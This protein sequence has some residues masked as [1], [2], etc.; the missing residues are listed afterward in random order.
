MRILPFLL[1]VPLSPLTLHAQWQWTQ[2]I[3]S[4]T[5]DGYEWGHAC[6]VGPDHTLA[7]AGLWREHARLG[8]LEF[9][10]A[11]DPSV[12]H[13]FVA[14][15]DVLGVP[16]WMHDL[17]TAD[18]YPIGHID[19]GVDAE[20][21]LFVAGDAR[22]PLLVD[23][24]PGAGLDGSPDGREY[25][26]IKFAPD[27]TY[28]W[29]R[30]VPVPLFTGE[31]NAL[32]VD[33]AG[34][35]WL[36]GHDGTQRGHIFKLSG[37][38]GAELVHHTTEGAG[39]YVNDVKTDAA[40]NAYIIGFANNDFVIGGVTC[41]H[42]ADL[43]AST[44]QWIGKFDAGGA[45]QWFHVPS[46]SGQGFP[47]YPEG[48]LAVTPDGTVFTDAL[49]RMRFGDDTIS[50]GSP[51]L[52]GIYALDT[53]GNVLFARKANAT[54]GLYFTE[55]IG[56]AD[57]QALFLGHFNGNANVD[58][59]DTSVV[60]EPAGN[61]L[62]L[63]R[64]AAD[65]TTTA[66]KTGPHITAA[67]GLDLDANGAPAVCGEFSLQPAF[68]G[69]ALDGDWD[70][71]ALRSAPLPTLVQDNAA[72][73]VFRAFPNPA[74]TT[75]HLVGGPGGPV[76]LEVLDPTGRLLQRI[77]RFDPARGPL[78]LSALPPGPLLLRL[79]G[80]WGSTTLRIVHLP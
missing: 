16:V 45:P 44:S 60:V 62:M 14:K 32:D 1:L 40:G 79:A 47:V 66:V 6:A 55:A 72:A 4:T 38:D 36:V 48:N 67:R 19:M 43:G 80:A 77:T 13:G 76:T 63:V 69:L 78:D 23:G 30:H 74:H 21:D 12:V 51:G 57:G 17:S 26:L 56:T 33:D 18:G 7:V 52:R 39:C 10:D 28:L 2:A 25:F 34:D 3:Q 24:A 59:I 71:F 58:L 42:N 27:G 68:D 9:A 50:T 65:G 41:P 49:K 29:G 31:L 37:A 73:P 61:T 11:D 53:D 64:Y 75:V 5:A 15:M 22:G 46:Q 20:G 8:P 70:L 54:S 35:A